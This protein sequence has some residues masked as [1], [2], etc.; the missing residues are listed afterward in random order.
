MRLRQFILLILI[1]LSG[2]LYYF[3][4]AEEAKTSLMVNKAIDGDT[5]DTAFGRVRLLG[6]NT[7]EKEQPFYA[8]AQNY[9]KQFEGRELQFEIHEKDK[10]GRFLAYVFD[11]EELVNKNIIEKGFANLYYYGEDRYY[12]DMKKAEE[13]AR[14][15]EFG[16]WK[17]SNNS[18]CIELTNFKPVDVEGEKEI[19][20]LK[21]NCNHSLSIIIKDDANHI[22]N[23]EINSNSVLRKELQ[24][25]FN[26]DGDSLFIRDSGGLILFYRY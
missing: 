6:I 23:E 11:G 15:N 16:L 19:L 22:Y 8:E 9:L 25:I 13:S 17:K 3:Y 24:N 14:K 5:L 12:S 21:N 20:E 1:I 10:Y 2:I 18:G 7:P 26:D 4:T